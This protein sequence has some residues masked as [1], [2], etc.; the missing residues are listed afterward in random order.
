MVV[1]CVCACMHV[2]VCVRACVCV[3]LLTEPLLNMHDLD[4]TDVDAWKAV[5]NTIKTQYLQYVSARAAPYTTICLTN[6]FQV[7]VR[8]KWSI[9]ILW[10]VPRVKATF[11][12]SFCKVV[13]G[14]PSDSHK[15]S[16]VIHN[17]KTKQVS[18]IKYLVVT[19][20]HLLSWKDNIETLCKRT[21]QRI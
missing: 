9:T 17:E 16:V 14:S 18:S 10:C 21:K 3:S 12:K 11:H 2:C 4:S 5:T 20:D 6:V 7:F 19:I 15:V 1:W 8:S 13:F